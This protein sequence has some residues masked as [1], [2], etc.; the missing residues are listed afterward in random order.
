MHPRT[1]IGK[2]IGGFCAI[3]GVFGIIIKFNAFTIYAKFCII[4]KSCEHFA[5]LYSIVPSI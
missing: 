4:I 5:R 1:P 3:S 2:I